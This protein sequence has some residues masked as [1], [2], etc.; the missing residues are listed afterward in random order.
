MGP[1]STRALRMPGEAR[2][3][4]GFTLMEL[5]DGLDYLNPQAPARGFQ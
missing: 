1:Q 3:R 2:R 5:L 4:G